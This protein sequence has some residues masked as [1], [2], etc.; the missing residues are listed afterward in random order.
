M[1]LCNRRSFLRS[2]ASTAGVA[3]L[4]TRAWTK[5]EPAATETIIDTHVHFYDPTRP[6][7]VPWPG[8]DDK[9]LY[10][11][12]LPENLRALT[13][14]Q[15]VAGCIVVE[16]SPWLEDNQWILDLAKDDPFVLGLVGHLEPGKEDFR[17]HL[18]RFAKNPLF[19]GIRIGQAPLQKEPSG[20]IDDLKQLVTKDLAL[21][22]NGG[23]DLPEAVATLAQRLPELRI[24]INHAANVPSNGKT[25]P[26]RWLTGMRAAAKRRNV[27]CKVSALVEGTGR[28]K[29]DAPKETGYYQPVL[30]ALWKAFGEDRLLFGSNWPV[31]EHAASYATV[32]G[33][34]CEYFQGKGGGA[35]R[36]FFHENAGAAYK[37]PKR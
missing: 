21:D 6:Q 17:K 35:S 24:I 3:A 33:I 4:S 1:T 7:G 23:P 16:A 20:F 15:K 28:N 25:V 19:R 32:V 29:G 13:R 27:Y 11:P 9:V 5:D 2:A 8:K 10:R 37:W 26:D 12:C 36:K 14:G 18:D 30:D 22:V 31:S 34:V